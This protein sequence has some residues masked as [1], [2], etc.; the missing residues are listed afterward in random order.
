ME[1]ALSAD[2]I[3]RHLAKL[4]RRDEISPE[5]ERAIR[6][7]VTEPRQV[8]ADK[9]LIRKGEELSQSM[10][11]LDGMLARFK[12]S[13][14]G[15]RQLLELHV[16][17]DFADLHSFTL[18]RLDHNVM[19]LTP[20]RIATVSH[21][22]LR[23]ISEQFPHLTRVYWF[24]TNLD[25]AIQR[26][27]TMSLGRRGAA[28]RIAHLFCELYVRLEIVG[29]TRGLE[30]DCP[31]TQADIAEYVG[32]TPVHVNRML[33]KLRGEELIRFEHRV[34]TICDWPALQRTAEFDP[35]YLYLERKAR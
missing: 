26:E 28:A 20:C 29:L 8:P 15:H 18:K 5:E 2:L 12:D 24:L 1:P 22:R 33:Q 25:A 35:G 17:G 13:R 19:S 21:D 16:P 11:L 32:L 3:D 34:L 31:L 9:V 7:I 4:R 27:W 23:R 30:F 14:D 6:S 10:L